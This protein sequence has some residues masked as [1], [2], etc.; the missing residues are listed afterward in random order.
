[1]A[2]TLTSQDIKEFLTSLGSTIE[3]IATVFNECDLIGLEIWQ[4]RFDEYT[5]ILAAISLSNLAFASAE[6]FGCL[7]DSLTTLSRNISEI[8]NAQNQEK[9]E[10]HVGFHSSTGGRPAYDISK[11]TIEQLRE[12]GMNWRSIAVCLG[13][14]D[15]TLYR[16]RIHFG[17][18]NNFTDITEEEL[19]D[20]IKLTLNLTPYSGESYV[21]G[22][23]KG[24]GINVQRWRIRESLARLDGIGRAIRTRFAICRRTY[25]VSGPNHLW[26]IDSNHKLISWRFVIHG[27]ID[28]YSRAII[29]LKCCTNNKAATVL[30]YFEQGVHEFG[31]PSRVRG[32]QGIENVNVARYMITNRGS[33]RGSFIAGRSVHNQRIE[34]LWAEVNRVSSALYKDVFQ[35][36]ENSNALNSL[37][38]V[39][40]W[41]LHYVY[42]PRINASLDE[43]KSQWNHHGLRTTGHQSPLALWANAMIHATD[44][45]NVINWQTYGIDNDGLISNI[46]S[47]NNV[48]VPEA[49]LQLCEQQL[50][51]LQQRVNPLADDGNNGIS[52][53]YDTV[54]F[55][56]RLL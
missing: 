15:Q 49:S 8:L 16:R 54:N 31:L 55:L 23:L 7:S 22:S 41:A 5:T 27:C 14:S 2:D 39:H 18:D 26:H 44:E 10:R 33:D 46:D 47:N 28:G 3:R 45:S 51:E 11:S 56:Q 25:N 42:L 17:I 9:E 38:E 36:L 48:V 53:F 19:D 13:V 30:H 12:T 34:R 1:M 37:D 52:H 43:F 32:D 21:R 20:Q 29:Y 24:R 35:F 6:L 50:Q 40:L 4:R